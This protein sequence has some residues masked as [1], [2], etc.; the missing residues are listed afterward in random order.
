MNYFNPQDL[1]EEFHRSVGAPIRHNNPTLDF[2][3]LGLRLDLLAE[4]YEEVLDAV[5]SGDVADVAKELADLVYVTYGFAVEAGIPL[6]IIVAEIHASNMSKLDEDGKPIV[7]HDGKVLK[8]PN[9]REAQ[10]KE[11]LKLAN[12]K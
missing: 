12:A 1:V 5:H 7:R 11:I 3:R 4:E 6:D 8:G 2:D 10:V 9:Y